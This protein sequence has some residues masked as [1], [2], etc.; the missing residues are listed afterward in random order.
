MIDASAVD[1]GGNTDC[2]ENTGC[3]MF[4]L[5]TIKDTVKVRRTTTVDVGD[6]QIM[7]TPLLSQSTS[8]KSFAPQR[9]LRGSLLC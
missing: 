2:T 6:P 7:A 9:A 5:A 1:F 3:E 4:V 8:T